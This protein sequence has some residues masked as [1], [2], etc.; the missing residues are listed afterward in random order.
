MP[1]LPG[2]TAALRAVIPVELQQPPPA[3]VADIRRRFERGR[4]RRLGRAPHARKEVA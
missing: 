3:H 1:A 2:L 4:V